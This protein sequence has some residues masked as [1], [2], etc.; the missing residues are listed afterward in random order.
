MASAN[1]KEPTGLA[2]WDEIESKYWESM[3]QA[4]ADEDKKLQE[5]F[6]ISS[7]K[8]KEVIL[9]KCDERAELYARIDTL[10]AEIAELDGRIWKVDKEREANVAAIAQSREAD[11]AAKRQ[12]F[13]NYRRGKRY[14][15][16]DNP[17]EDDEQTVIND[18]ATGLR[19]PAETNV[20]NGD[21]NSG[22]DD[23]GGSHGMELDPPEHEPEPEKKEEEEREQEPEQEEEPEQDQQADNSAVSSEDPV[24]GV[25]VY[26]GSGELLGKL[27][28]LT[29]R[30]NH[31]VSNMMRLPVKRPVHIRPGR[32]FTHEHLESIY[33]PSDAKGAKWLSL[34]IQATG[35][36]QAQPCQTCTKN[37]G[38]YSHCIILGG[39]E[40]PRCGNCEWNRQGCHGASLQARPKSRHSA[41]NSVDKAGLPA[42][43]LAPVQQTIATSGGFTPV[44]N[45]LFSQKT[46]ADGNSGYQTDKDM[47]LRQ[48]TSSRKSLPNKR[49]PATTAAES[50]VAVAAVATTTSTPMTG[51]PAADSEQ[52]HGEHA[53]LPEINKE[54]LILRD[55]GVVFTDPPC[56]RG[57]P[58]VK[59]S[60]SHPYWEEDWVAIEE[61]VEP[62]LKRWSDK[63]E[64][65][66][67]VGGTQSSKFLANRQVNRGKAI[68]RFL[69]EGELHPYQILGKPYVNKQL[70]NY[71]TL[72]RM[73]Q[74][75]EELQKFAIDITPSQWLRQR[76]CEVCVEMGDNFNLAKT[77]HDLYH[78]PKVVSIRAKSGFGNIGRPSGY[79]M[80]REKAAAAAAGTDGAT[81]KRGPRQQQQQQ[82]HQQQPASPHPRASYQR[83]TRGASADGAAAH[84]PDHPPAAAA[85]SKAAQN[86]SPSKQKEAKKQRLTISTA[87]EDLEY[88]GYTS[89]D[90]YSSDHVMPVDWRVYQVKT[91]LISTNTLVTQYWHWVDRAETGSSE[92]NMFE[93]QVLKDVLPNRVTWGVYKDPIDFHLRLAELTEITYAAE[94]LKVVIG[95]KRVEGVEWRGDVLAHFKRERTKRRFL[96]FMR[97]KGVR[98]V[99]TNASYVDA[100]WENVQSDVLPHY[101][102]D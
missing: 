86:V 85:A 61:V 83:K 91:S 60:P 52:G 37:T 80:E 29:T 6:N 8:L 67:V 27:R 10:N 21:G 14:E 57:V 22:G 65:Y 77:I 102:S 68:L 78:D 32:R 45:A 94:S 17:A 5:E 74:V 100:A 20:T 36:I 87:A 82:Q 84:I 46:S 63:Y 54:T 28:R 79:R 7:G 99:R 39:E 96:T 90:S 70:T 1:G 75:L 89:A 69:Q 58:L 15:D 92:E 24:V 50:S 44:N 16:D 53:D 2:L 25:E 9:S 93:H 3:R 41:A 64:H 48:K 98:L 38:V 26:D 51:S 18:E 31:W 56:M 66:K 49:K 23:E 35:E 62:H 72:F 43:K 11:D 40:F 55:D 88:S 101:D 59:I 97:K 4:R 81:P 71:D 13:K 73:V 95:T 34:Y 12:L 42:E 47:S 76:L 30:D 33:E 19:P